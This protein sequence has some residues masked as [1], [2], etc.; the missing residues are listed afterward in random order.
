MAQFKTALD[1]EKSRVI[2]LDY[3]TGANLEELVALYGEQPVFDAA[4]DSIIISIQSNVRRYM[5]AGK[6]DQEIKDL[7]AAYKPGVRGPRVA[8][9]ALT[10][11][12]IIAKL[13]SG[14]IKLNDEQKEKALALLG[15]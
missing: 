6:S 15:K 4:V 1:K 2:I 10:T 12:E 5:K 14:E 7:V 9:K 13:V 8:T 3:K 11:D